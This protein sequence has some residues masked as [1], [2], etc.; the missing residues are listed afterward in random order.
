MGKLNNQKGIFPSQYAIYY[1]CKNFYNL[2]DF[3]VKLCIYMTCN[4]KT[5]RISSFNTCYVY[6]SIYIYNLNGRSIER[7]ERGR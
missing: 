1:Y 2:P 3:I 5:N 6:I 4:Q 7:E